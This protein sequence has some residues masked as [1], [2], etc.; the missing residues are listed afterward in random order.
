MGSDFEDFHF[1]RLFKGL[2]FPFREAFLRFFDAIRVTFNGNELAVMHQSIDQGDHTAGVGE[3]L[4]PFGKGL[5]GREDD[6]AF[7]IVTPGDD[8]EEQVCIAGVVGEIADLIYA[9]QLWMTV[10]PQTPSEGEV[11]VLGSQIIEHVAGGDTASGRDR[12]VVSAAPI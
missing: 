12:K 5:V 4:G 3:D 2:A 8:L 7:V 11:G 1:D 6:G 10:P 9:E